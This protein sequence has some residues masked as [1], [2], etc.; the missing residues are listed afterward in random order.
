MGHTKVRCPQAGAKPEAAAEGND[1]GNYG[2]G[3][4]VDG[5]DG[6]DSWG[7][8]AGESAPVQCGW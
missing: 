7:Q 8:A 1:D 3:N 4:G 2:G 6:G 5:V